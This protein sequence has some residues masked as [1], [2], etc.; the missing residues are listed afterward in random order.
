M[1]FIKT[2]TP[3]KFISGVSRK[4]ALFEASQA[5]GL[6]EFGLIAMTVDFGDPQIFLV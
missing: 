1:S 6:C 5:R 3:Q 4:K 2:F